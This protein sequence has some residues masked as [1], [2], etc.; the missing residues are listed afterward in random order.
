MSKVAA[1][2]NAFSFRAAC[3][4]LV[5]TLGM[6]LFIDETGR[7]IWGES[8]RTLNVMDGLPF[9]V[10]MKVLAHSVDWSRETLALQVALLGDLELLINLDY[11]G[12]YVMVFLY[13]KSRVMDSSY[14]KK[15]SFSRRLVFKGLQ[16]AVVGVYRDWETDRKSTRLNSSHSGES[17]MPS[18]A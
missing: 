13:D 6:N 8:K 14:L 4:V 9:V 16:K 15:D 10:P 18:S 5:D 11:I 3:Y 17:R 1:T 7:K 12:G 2:S